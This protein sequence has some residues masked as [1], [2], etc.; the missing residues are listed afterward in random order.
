MS[1]RKSSVLQEVKTKAAALLAAR[2]RQVL[3]RDKHHP[4][5][6]SSLSRE[7][8]QSMEI[9]SKKYNCATNTHNKSIRTVILIKLFTMTDVCAESHRSSVCFV[10][11]PESTPFG[12]YISLRY[13]GMGGA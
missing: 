5:T 2:L 6:W 10:R 3:R 4:N 9:R 1:Y 12:G 8:A 7:R 11:A 13:T